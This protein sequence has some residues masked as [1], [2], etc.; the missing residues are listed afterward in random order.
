MSRDHVL[1]KIRTALGRS[2]GQGAAPPLELRLDAKEVP[3]AERIAS[4]GA[5]LAALGG[6]LHTAESPGAV[7]AIAEA[8]LAG[9]AAVRSRSPLVAALDLP[10]D[11]AWTDVREAAAGAEAGITAAAYGL[12]DT[13]TLVVF[14]SETEARLLSL[15]PPVHI[16]VLERQRLLSG[17]DELFLR[18]PRPLAETS[19]M[20]L[21]TGPSRTADIELILVRGVHGPGELH[22]ILV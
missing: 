8:I 4:F 6:T 3:L 1:H 5:A 10:G 9:R 19:A 13:G 17:L 21:I 12:A 2:A 15:L 22:V 20:V 14:A 11:G 16:A 18:H 7:W